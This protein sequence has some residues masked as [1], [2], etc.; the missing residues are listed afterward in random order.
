MIMTEQE[1]T[2]SDQ[3]L[4]AELDKIRS[5]IEDDMIPSVENILEMVGKN[6]QPHEIYDLTE[7]FRKL[8]NNFHTI[9]IMAESALRVGDDQ[10]LLALVAD[11][12]QVS[13]RL[14]IIA[15]DLSAKIK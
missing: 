1:R 7:G 3:K 11:L 2:S 13:D 5:T 10:D 12:T 9:I 15:S 4:K 14:E 8:K 6:T